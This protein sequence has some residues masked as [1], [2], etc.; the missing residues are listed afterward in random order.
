MGLSNHVWFPFN[1][2]LRC[3]SM[4][5][6]I[7]MAGVGITVFFVYVLATLWK[8]S[9]SSS[10]RDLE[11]YLAKSQPRRKRGE[12]IE[13]QVNPAV[14]KFSTRVVGRMALGGLVVLGMAIPFHGQQSTNGPQPASTPEN[15][16]VT[17]NSQVPQEV[18]QELDAMKKRIEELEAQLKQPG[19]AAPP[20]AQN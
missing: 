3:R 11:V 14:R 17:N 7:A 20:P 16:A 12:L 8:E 6:A 15:P 18:L 1:R 10:A 13:M 5:I 9:I 2:N 19:S 4:K